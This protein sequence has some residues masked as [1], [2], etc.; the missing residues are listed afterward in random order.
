MSGLGLVLATGG[1]GGHIYPAL[2][3]AEAATAGGHRVGVLGR[4]NGMEAQVVPAA[5]VAFHGV[6]AGKWDRGRPD[7]SQAVRAL[8][9]VVEA[10]GWLR[11]ERPDAVIGFGGYASFPGCL[12]ATLLGIPLLLYEGNAFPGRVT[13]WFAPRA[14]TV[15]ATQPALEQHLLTLVMGGSQGSLALNRALPEAWERLELS[16]EHIVLH[17][18][19]SRWIDD[20]RLRTAALPGYRPEPYLDATLAWPA[21]DLAITRAGFSTLAEAAAYGVPLI[22]IPLPSS[23]EDH[24]RHNAAALESAGA[25][26]L[27]EEADLAS[28]PEVWRSM[29]DPERRAAAAE[30]ARGRADP[31]AADTIVHHIESATAGR[32]RRARRAA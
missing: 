17:S 14:A 30:A 11:R 4:R 27:L 6:R 16:D 26:R 15:L 9:G 32:R 10:L 25:G 12:A 2:A 5:G 24:Q 8:S 19:G 28:L 7:P 18:S 1:T 23:A 13:R 21:S 3:V 29:L 22:A 31:G 20:L